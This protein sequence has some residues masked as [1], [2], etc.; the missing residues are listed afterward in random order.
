MFQGLINI[1]KYFIKLKAEKQIIGVIGGALL[2]IGFL[3]FKERSSNLNS[4]NEYK[5]HIQKMND[6]CQ[7]EKKE[8]QRQVAYWKD[9]LASEKLFNAINEINEMKK[10]ANDVKV[11]EN[12]VSKKTQEIKQ[13]QS[14]LLKKINK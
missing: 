11:I 13:K 1:W 2:F 7:L 6:T 5:K 4:S 12:R 10:I 8:L 9:S 14:N 3:F